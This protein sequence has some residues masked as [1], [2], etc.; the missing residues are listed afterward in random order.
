[1]KSET[2]ITFNFRWVALSVTPARE[3]IYPATQ[4]MMTSATDCEGQSH[5]L[6]APTARDMMPSITYV[7]DSQEKGFDCLVS[8]HASSLRVCDSA[9]GEDECL[10]GTSLAPDIPLLV[11]PL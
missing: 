1:M 3:R 5:S 4:R 6:D 9:E 7:E 10:L 11:A 8:D 2:L